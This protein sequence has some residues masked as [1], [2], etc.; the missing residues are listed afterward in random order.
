MLILE[1]AC[2]SWVILWKF[3]FSVFSKKAWFMLGQPPHLKKNIIKIQLCKKMKLRGDWGWPLFP[4][5]TGKEEVLW[6]WTGEPRAAAEAADWEDGTGSLAAP[7]GGGQAHSL[8]AGTGPCE[9]HGAAEADEEGGKCGR[10]E[11]SWSPASVSSR[12]ASTF[13][14][15]RSWGGSSWCFSR[16]LLLFLWYICFFFLR[17]CCLATLGWVFLG[18]NYLLINLLPLSKGQEWGWKDATATAQREH[19][20]EDGWLC[21]KKANYGKAEIRLPQLQDWIGQSRLKHP[22]PLRDWQSVNYHQLL[23]RFQ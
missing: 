4:S 22:S 14:H 16:K 8:R 3:I 11:E 15:S 7:A 20:G 2:I 13:L 19:E 17:F 6:H 12:K 23:F 21:P 18:L 1:L 5:H 10:M 9:I